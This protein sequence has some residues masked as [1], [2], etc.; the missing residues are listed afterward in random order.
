[1]TEPA[2][3]ILVVVFAVFSVTL[4]VMHVLLKL[5]VVGIVS[6]IC[7]PTT[8]EGSTHY[9]A[10]DCFKYRVIMFPCVNFEIASIFIHMYNDVYLE[11]FWSSGS[12]MVIILQKTE[13]CRHMQHFFCHYIYQKGIYDG[14]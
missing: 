14:L 9:T 5:N 12:K 6:L 4:I 2:N 8:S 10:M 13:F 7:A 3:I 11:K 1:M